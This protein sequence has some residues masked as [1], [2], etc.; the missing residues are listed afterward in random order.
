MPN[1]PDSNND[2]ALRAYAEQRRTQAG[3]PGELHPV[4]RRLLQAEIARMHGSPNA[5]AAPRANWFAGLWP[6][7]ATTS[8]LIVAG[9][10]AFR[11]TRDDTAPQRETPALTLAETAGAPAPTTSPTPPAPAAAPK[12]AAL[13]EPAPVELRD[14]PAEPQ[15]LAIASEPQAA[16]RFRRARPVIEAKDASV[17]AD[18]AG[19]PLAAVPARYFKQQVIHSASA[20]ENETRARLNEVD[21]AAVGVAGVK[22]GKSLAATAVVLDRFAVEQ[23]G[24]ELRFLDAD[25]SVYTGTVEVAIAGTDVVTSLAAGGSPATEPLANSVRRQAPSFAAVATNPPAT[26]QWMFKAYGINRTLQQPVI[27]DGSLQGSLHPGNGTD[28]E[29]LSRSIVPQ[30]TSASAAQSRTSPTQSSDTK[31][32][33]GATAAGSYQQL[34][35]QRLN[36]TRIQGKVRVGSNSPMQNLDALPETK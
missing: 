7:L 2:Q 19:A 29:P 18:A 4:N 12:P 17:R 13:A 14:A 28:A 6:R 10:F 20:P 30:A 9:V 34:N 15:R 1:E 31:E 8:V 23:S 5:P 21:A 16:Q 24:R 11:S 32:K 26:T 36:A 25:G 35:Y 22:I 27:V 3:A 33:S